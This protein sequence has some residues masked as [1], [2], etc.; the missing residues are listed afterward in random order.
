[1]ELFAGFFGMVLCALAIFYCIVMILLPIFVYQIAQ[2]T[3][4]TEV[5]L[6]RILDI[7]ALEAS[8]RSRKPVPKLLKST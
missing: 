6:R 8:D 3:K 2:S 5:Y 7:V 4:M 1:M